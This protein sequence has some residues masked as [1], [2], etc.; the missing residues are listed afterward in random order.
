[1]KF[2]TLTC[3]LLLCLSVIAV[4]LGGC[5]NTGDTPPSTPSTEA[6]TRLETAETANATETV[7]TVETAEATETVE[8]VETTETAD[9]QNDSDI[10]SE[11]VPESETASDT[12]TE[13]EIDTEASTVPEPETNGETES[14][15]ETD[16]ESV[17]EPESETATQTETET[18]TKPETETEADTETDSETKAE[19]ETGADTEADTDTDTDTETDTNPE[20]EV[21]PET[22]TEPEPETTYDPAVYVVI[23]TARELM[24]FNRAVNRESADFRGMTLLLLSDLDMAGYTWTPLDGDRLADFTFDGGG[25]TISNLRFPDHTYPADSEPPSHGKGCGFV[26]VVTEAITFRDLTL[27]GAEVAVY[28]HSVGN[29]VGGVYGGQAVFENCR[30]VGFTA[31]GPL[32]YTESPSPYAMRMGGFVGSVDGDGAVSFTGCTVEDLT[33]LGFHDM[34]GFVGRD[35]TGG[36]D[37]S[38]FTACAVRGAEITFSYFQHT[39]YDPEQPK[40]FVSVFFNNHD[41]TDNLD[42]L[43]ETGN[44]YENV[45]YYDAV[46]DTVYPAEEFRSTTNEEAQA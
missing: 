19:T 1:M 43:E 4:T 3:L 9:T 38:N 15:A 26:G 37:A 18:E 41:H 36:L 40:K 17:A 44:T 29:F 7:E 21:E 5:R 13:I 2:T 20:T 32:D 35:L 23:R 42:T 24:D 27:S 14:D 33:L 10:E 31:N 16:T 12:E 34:A 46:Y 6:A 25:H 39:A 30:S 22:D 45:V 28:D 11:T 8:T